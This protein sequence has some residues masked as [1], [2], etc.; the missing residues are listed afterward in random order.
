[1]EAR[2][3][4]Q[5][6]QN[7]AS[8]EAS[9]TATPTKVSDEGMGS[10]G[11]TPFPTEFDTP[12]SFVSTGT[13]GKLVCDNIIELRRKAKQKIQKEDFEQALPLLHEVIGLSPNSANLYRLRCLCYSRLNMHQESLQDA[14][15][16]QKLKPESCTSYFHMGSAL[17][18][19]RDYF[20]A[21]KSF[22]KGLLLNPQDK[23]LK[24]GFWNAVTMITNLRNTTL[25]TNSG[26]TGLDKIDMSSAHVEGQTS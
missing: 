24:E 13:P 26:P 4:D 21:A 15:V 7:Q 6:L 2:S 14:Y 1:M 22:Q 11:S 25:G 17:Y 16:I 19:V 23:A 10:T 18:G 9:S 3:L 8:G 20:A 5:M 12:T